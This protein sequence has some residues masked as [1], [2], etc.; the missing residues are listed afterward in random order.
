MLFSG[1]KNDFRNKNSNRFLVFILAVDLM[2]IGIHLAMKLEIIEMPGKFWLDW[3]RGYTEYFQ[4]LKYIGIVLCSLYL[5]LEQRKLSFLPWAFLF[6]VLLLDDAFTFHERGGEYLVDYLGLRSSFG[7]R[8]VD[9]GELAYHA[10]VGALFSVF[11]GAA[12]IKG[13][14]IFKRTC[15]DI[16]LLFSLF[17]LFGV[18]VDMVHSYYNYVDILSGALVLIEDGGE[19]ISLSL[20][21]WYFFFLAN[22][23]PNNGGFLFLNLLRK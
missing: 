1:L 16:V 18:V 22:K 3:E 6:F 20:L 23:S 2:F 13:S 7:L 21:A 5:S 10:T 9:F 11:I 8:A 12:Y 17:V 14:Q 15:I 4:Y 19:M